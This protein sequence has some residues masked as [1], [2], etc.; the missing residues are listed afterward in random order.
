MKVLTALVL[1]FSLPGAHFSAPAR[2]PV[3]ANP[4]RQSLRK[5]GRW[6]LAGNGHAVY[7]YG[8]VVLMPDVYGGI[9]YVATFCQ[10][11]KPMVPLKD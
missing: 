7:C 8:P 1:L 4:T 10:G 6:Y 5:G 11:D 2:K 3:P 9:Q